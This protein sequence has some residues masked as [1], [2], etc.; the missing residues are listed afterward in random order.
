MYDLRDGLMGRQIGASKR[1][2]LK[3]AIPQV[4]TVFVQRFMDPVSMTEDSVAAFQ[5]QALS[6]QVQ[7]IH[8]TQEPPGRVQFYELPGGTPQNRSGK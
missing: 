3:F 6:F 2:F 1:H 4:M 7:V 8:Q 5:L